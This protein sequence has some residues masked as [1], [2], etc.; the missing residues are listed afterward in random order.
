M[1]S[2]DAL[3]AGSIPG[4]YDELLVPCLFA[5]YAADLARRAAEGNAPRILEIAAGTGAVTAALRAAVPEAEITATDLNQA[6]LD[7]AAARIGGQS[8]TFRQADAGALPFVDGMFDLAVCQFGVM[9]FPD[10]VRAHRET[11][12]VLKPGGRFLFNTWDR[13]EENQAS[14]V[15]T[16]ALAA[17]FPANPPTF[18]ARVPFGYHDKEQI[19]AD[20]QAAGFRV[21]A[22]DTVRLPCRAPSAKALAVGLCHGSPLRNELE[23]LGGDA[24][25]RGTEA[26]TE[27]LERLSGPS[28]LDTTMSAHVIS[29]QTD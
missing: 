5:P 9:F 14:A 24:L 6:M 20:L 26:A 3:F 19:A 17:L 15:L 25:K 11:R 29:A 2:S 10:R 16:D 27:A 18:L 1:A 22:I 8:M 12:R 7:T 28:G 21:I 13:I 23:A 4:L